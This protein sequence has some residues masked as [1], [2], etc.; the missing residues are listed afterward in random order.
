VASKMCS[1]L[2]NWVKMSGAAIVTN[3]SSTRVRVSQ[4]MFPTA[5]DDSPIHNAG[6]SLH[7]G[8]RYATASG[9][10]GE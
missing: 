7:V 4:T 9:A 6:E 3:Q 1:R 8:A 10:D 2:A 5:G